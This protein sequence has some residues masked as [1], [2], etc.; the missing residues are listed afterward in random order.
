VARVKTDHPAVW[1]DFDVEDDAAS[2]AEVELAS[3]VV[4]LQMKWEKWSAR[5]SYNLERRFSHVQEDP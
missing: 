3:L 2:Q 1:I 4:L 5:I